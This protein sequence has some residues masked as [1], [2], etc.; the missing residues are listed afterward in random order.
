MPGLILYISAS[1][2]VTDNCQ[3]EAIQHHQYDSS[4]LTGI[5]IFFSS[6][7]ALTWSLGKPDG[8]SCDK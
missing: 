6:E 4:D 7:L 8:R 5:L 2:G 3:D 1:R